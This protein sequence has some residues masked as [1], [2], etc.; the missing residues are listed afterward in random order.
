[1]ETASMGVVYADIELI[2][3]ADLI[4]VQ[5]GYLEENTGKANPG[6][7]SGRILQSNPIPALSG[8]TCTDFHFVPFIAFSWLLSK[9]F[10]DWSR[11]ID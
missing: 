8:K 9:S 3:G 7:C 6:C 1:M 10:P 4:L 2:R 5:E 11:T